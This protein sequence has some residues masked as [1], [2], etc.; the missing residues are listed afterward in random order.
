ME[1]IS[2][3]DKLPEEK[4]GL[5]LVTDGKLVDKCEWVSSYLSPNDKPADKCA[6]FNSSSYM[7]ILPFFM[8]K[9]T[10]WMPFPKPPKE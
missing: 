9:V 6:W 10:H 3:K 2:V 7:W 4:E 5:Y 1:W 8:K